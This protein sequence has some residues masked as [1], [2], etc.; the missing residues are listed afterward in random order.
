MPE[1]PTRAPR[2]A[3][4][5]AGVAVA[6]ALA[7]AAIAALLVNIQE[8]KA[9]ARDPYLKLV[10]VGDDTTDPTAWG[11]NWPRQYDSYRRTVDTTYTRYGGSDGTPARSRL[12]ADPWLVRMFAGYAFALDF[13][14]RRGHAYMLDDQRQTRRITER[15]QPGA[16]LHCHASVIPTYR[17]LG[18]GDVRAGF[19]ALSRMSYGDAYAEVVETGSLNPVPE[20]DTQGFAHEPGAHPV[21]CVDCHDPQTMAVRVSRPGFLAGIAA[22]AAGDAPV[23]HLA[24]IE[25]WRRGG[26]DA[27]YDANAD[28]SRQEMRSFVCGQC[29]VEYYC[30]PKT[31]LFY[32]WSQ[33]LRV[34]QIEAV[35]EETRFPDGEPFYDWQHGETGARVFKAQH[36]E[37]ETWSQGVHARAGVAC[38]DC[39]MPY[40][41]EGALKVSDHWVRSPLLNVARACQPC[42]PV[43]EAELQARVAA[44]QD[45]THALMDRSAAALVDMLDAIAA[46][47]AA[48]AGDAALA[49]ALALQ[50][51]AQ[52]RLD[53]VNAEN[54]M[55]FHAD[56]ESAR[57]LGEAIDY[58]RQAVSANQ[59]RAAI[60]PA[61]NA[62]KQNA[63]R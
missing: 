11:V 29:H 27:P 25:R 32:P 6:A 60:P 50:R 5:L 37:F 31:T 8:R 48:G 21:S 9:E 46:A 17:R 1:R 36:P 41:R 56:Q 24:S 52:W 15:P 61:S 62:E 40:V 22:L 20:G 54:S 55:G 28:A 45:R 44:I 38:A 33:G 7:T 10:R 12:E 2:T 57:I 16:C 42:H 13:R 51:K 49:P 23:P 26:R 19:E 34:E 18:D 47:K 63:E 4:I 30:G 35:Y 3:A 53:F 14:E 59:T 39:H 43:A 58:A